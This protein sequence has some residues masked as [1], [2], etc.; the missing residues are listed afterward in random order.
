MTLFTEPEFKS[1]N[2]K[3][4]KEYYIKTNHLSSR[5]GPSLSELSEELN[6]TFY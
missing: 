6:N 4:V 2:S 1:K 5:I 3:S